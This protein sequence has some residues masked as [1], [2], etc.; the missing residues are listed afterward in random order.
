MHVLLIL[1]MESVA[2]IHHKST[3]FTRIILQIDGGISLKPAE[4]IFKSYRQKFVRAGWNRKTIF[5]VK[6]SVSD[7]C[8]PESDSVL[9]FLLNLI[10]LFL[11]VVFFYASDRLKK[12]MLLRRSLTR[13][14]RLLSYLIANNTFHVHFS[15]SSLYDRLHTRAFIFESKFRVSVRP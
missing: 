15:A 3:I 6:M 2:V 8:S 9:T 7:V 5:A 11:A 13:V 14:S 10:V 1:F 4:A 12:W